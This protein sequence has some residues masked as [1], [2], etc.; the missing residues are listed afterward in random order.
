MDALH[1]P[2]RYRWVVLAV[3][4]LIT[5]LNCVQWIMFAP[6]SD[7]VKHVVGCSG[8]AVDCLS[9]IFMASYTLLA[10]PAL[11]INSLFGLRGAIVAG[12]AATALGAMLRCWPASI[13][14]QS[15]WYR[16][17]ETAVLF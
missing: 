8:L 11:R 2:V 7:K 13:S 6:I 12:A 16:S 14:S 1:R 5:C 15:R 3:F 10:I 4:S 17:C 9:L